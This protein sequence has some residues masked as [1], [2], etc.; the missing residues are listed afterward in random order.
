[1]KTGTSKDMRDNWCMGYTS[2]YTVGV[3]VGNFNGEPMWN[4]SGISGAAPVWNA[5]MLALHGSPPS[6]QIAAKFESTSEPLPERT[7]SR[8]RYP[9]DQT[10]IG[11]DPDMPRSV[12]QLPI[13]IEN[14]QSGDQVFLNS[15]ILGTAS[16]RLDWPISLGRYVVE[17]KTARGDMIDRVQF[18]VR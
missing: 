1:V 11:Y 15:K 16:K 4:V 6:A 18:D 2:E 7:I 10:L 13:E 17:L 3:W 5:V 8:I 14:P 9:V 12:Q